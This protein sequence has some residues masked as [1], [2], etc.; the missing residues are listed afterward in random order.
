MKHLPFSQV[1]TISKTKD[2]YLQ[3]KKMSY[4][5]KNVKHKYF[6][7]NLIYQLLRLNKIYLNSYTSLILR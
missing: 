5:I 1:C 7:L 6:F 3:Q 4:W 2:A